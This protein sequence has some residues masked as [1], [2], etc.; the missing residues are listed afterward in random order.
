MHVMCFL[1][2]LCTY[3]RFIRLTS[4]NLNY[5]IVLGTVS[6]NLSVYMDIYPPVSTE[7]LAVFCIVS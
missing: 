7:V 4:P 1:S 6:L 3:N 5:M 2:Y